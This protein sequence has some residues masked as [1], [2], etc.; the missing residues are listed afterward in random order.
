MSQILA[1]FDLEGTLCQSGQIVWKA[2]I[3]RGMRQPGGIFR[4]IAHI[5]DQI[6]YNNLHKLKLIND[7]TKRRRA[8][9]GMAWL[10]RSMSLEQLQEFAEEI[11][12]RISTTVRADSM[13]ILANHKKQGHLVILCSGLFI[14]MLEV[15]GRVLDVSA[16]IGTDLEVRNNSCTGGTASE[17]CFDRHRADMIRQYL[18]ARNIVPDLAHSY[19]YGDTKWDIPVLAMV[20]HPVAVYPD[21]EL[22]DHAWYHGWKII[23]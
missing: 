3:R 12:A 14:P 8:I 2:I 18:Q 13:Q 9:A 10:L 11:A 6:A 22:R 17:I 1:I 16:V 20:G 19:A 5:L 23:C 4:V 7:Y 15:V 21:R